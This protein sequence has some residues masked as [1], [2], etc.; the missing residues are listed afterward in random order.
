MLEHVALRIPALSSLMVAPARQ[1]TAGV[2]VQANTCHETVSGPKAAA[3]S[4]KVRVD[5]GLIV[6]LGSTNA[7]ARAWLLEPLRS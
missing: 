1:F 5:G 3:D 4:R 7:N 6:R 2:N